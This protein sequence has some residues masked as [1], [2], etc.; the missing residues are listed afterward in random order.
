MRRMS[1][2]CWNAGNAGCLGELVK[3]TVVNAL[4]SVGFGDKGTLEKAADGNAVVIGTDVCALQPEAVR[5]WRGSLGDHTIGLGWDAG[6][7]VSVKQK[8]ND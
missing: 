1:E 4:V 2:Q 6:R 5:C 8:A 3:R 7:D